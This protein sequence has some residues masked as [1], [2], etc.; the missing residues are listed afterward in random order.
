MSLV[1]ISTSSEVKADQ[2]LISNMRQS[3]DTLLWT[4]LPQTLLLAHH[5]SFSLSLSLAYSLSLSLARSLSLCQSFS[6][7]FCSLDALCFSSSA[8]TWQSLLGVENKFLRQ[9]CC[10]E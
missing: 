6:C 9:L 10:K 5:S 2:D 7:S 3:L 4:L 8:Q 1:C